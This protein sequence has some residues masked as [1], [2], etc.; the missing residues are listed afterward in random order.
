MVNEQLPPVDLH[1]IVLARLDP[2]KRFSLSACI[3]TAMPYYSNVS[4]EADVTKIKTS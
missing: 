3:D 4:N 2:R 1:A